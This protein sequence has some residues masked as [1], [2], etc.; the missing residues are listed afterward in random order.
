MAMKA[1]AVAVTIS[2][3]ACILVTTWDY[4]RMAADDAEPRHTVL[5]DK[6]WVDAIP[7]G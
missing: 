3:L 4:Q 5:L 2:A 1:T 6:E 7:G